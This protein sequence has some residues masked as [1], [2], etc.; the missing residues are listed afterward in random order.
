MTGFMGKF[1]KKQ[2]VEHPYRFVIGFF[3]IFIGW[4]VL[5]ERADLPVVWHIHCGLDR[6]IPFVKYAV[7]PYSLW[8]L[9]MTQ[10][11]FHEVLRESGENRWRMLA[12]LFGGL[13]L[14]LLFCTLVPNGISLR[15]QAIPG[16]DLCARAVR[17]IESADNPTSVCP[18]MHVFS[19]IFL[20]FGVQR[21]KGYRHQF[22][23]PLAR[24][25]DVLICCSTMLLKQHS[26]IDVLCAVALAVTMDLT[27]EYLISRHA[28][29]AT[30]KT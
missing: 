20:D 14:I 21:A 17:F 10:S 11:M 4:F 22:V 9:W 3:V 8:F 26:I 28:M 18:S 15:P 30:A 2:C 6:Y 25:L 13:L 23:K 24:V 1:L 12:P 27:A 5:L 16:N 7:I 29:R 19:T